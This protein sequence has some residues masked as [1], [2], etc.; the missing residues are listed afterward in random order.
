MEAV[1]IQA[2]L[3]ELPIR[4]S[5]ISGTDRATRRKGSIRPETGWRA[6]SAVATIIIGL[7]GKEAMRG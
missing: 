4:L 3:L 1:L 7:P 5:L 6:P 2:R